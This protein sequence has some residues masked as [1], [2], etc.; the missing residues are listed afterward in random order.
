MIVDPEY[1]FPGGKVLHQR[2]RRKNWLKKQREIRKMK[3]SVTKKFCKYCGN[4]YPI[5]CFHRR[6]KKSPGRSSRCKFCAAEAQARVRQRHKVPSKR[7]APPGL[8][9]AIGQWVE[10]SKARRAEGRAAAAQRVAPA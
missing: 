8:A 6:S 3:E 7:P 4:T 1:D 10:L 5:D 9:K 2:L